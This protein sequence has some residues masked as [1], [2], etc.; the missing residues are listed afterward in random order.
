[1]TTNLAY[2]EKREH[3]AGLNLRTRNLHE[4]AYE[5]NPGFRR[6][7]DESGLTFRA[8]AEFKKVDLDAH[9][10]LYQRLAEQIWSTELAR[11]AAS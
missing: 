10:A 3:Y 1:M 5:H 2:I 11:E 4:R 7:I 9:Q 6:F 8:H